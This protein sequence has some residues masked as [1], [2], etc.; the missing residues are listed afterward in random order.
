MVDKPSNVRIVHARSDAG[1]IVF[2][3]A[4]ATRDLGKVTGTGG[5]NA[6]AL[7]T[8]LQAI[9]RTQRAVIVLEID[10]ELQ[11]QTNEGILNRQRV[12]F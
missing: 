6:R 12:N 11:A 2:A 7:R 10:G 8:V 9:A 3:V 1:S 4:V 5:H